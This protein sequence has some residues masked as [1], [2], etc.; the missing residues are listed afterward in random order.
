MLS[1]RTLAIPAF[2]LAIPAF[3]PAIPRNTP[4]I[5]VRPHL[6]TEDLSFKTSGMDFPWSFPPV[7]PIAPLAIPV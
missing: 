5:P 6:S 4:A 2:P 7:I 1:S 3:P